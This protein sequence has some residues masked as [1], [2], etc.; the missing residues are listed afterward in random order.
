MNILGR[1]I[2]FPITV[3]KSHNKFRVKNVISEEIVER[4]Q[5]NQTTSHSVG[6]VG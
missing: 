1:T 4:A 2:V 5:P 3:F 6:D